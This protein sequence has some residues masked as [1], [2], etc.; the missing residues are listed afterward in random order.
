VH[1]SRL[2]SL[3]A[4]WCAAAL[5]L[6][7]PAGAQQRPD[8]A[9][10]AGAV[11]ADHPLA[12]AAGAEV[13]RRGGNAVDAAITMAAVLAV[14]RPHVSGL[15]GDAIML[16]RDAA[17]GRVH[18]LNGSGRA[19]DLAA[20]DVFAAHGLGSVPADGLLSV[21]VP[22]AVRLWADALRRFGTL[23]LDAALA[24]AI[25][26]AENG[27][28]VSAKL[29]AEL[30]RQRPKLE[31][32]SA[33]RA[34]FLRNGEPPLIGT[35]LRQADLAGS[36]RLIGQDGPDV[37]YVGEIARRIDAF[38]A[39][40]GGLL[41]IEDLA[42][43]STLWQEPIATSYAGYRVL[44]MPP[45]TQGIALLMQ[46]NMAGTLDLEG[47]G[48]NTTEY[49]HALVELRRLAFEDRDRH[50]A[51]PAFVDVPL[52]QLLSMDHARRRVA[53]LSGG[54][55]A[56]NGVRSSGNGGDTG[57]GDAAF[58]AVI[59]RDGNA[60]SLAQSLYHPFGSGRVVPGTGIVLHNRGA[61]F[62]LDTAHPNVI[63]PRKRPVHALSPALALR[64]DGS[65]FMAFGT[66]GSDAQ[67]PTLLQVFHNVVLF[68][69]TP[70]QAVE[71]P[72]F[73]PLENGLLLIDDALPGLAWQALAGLGYSV[74][75]PPAPAAAMGGA[76]LIIVLPSGVRMI[77]ADPRREA[78]G[79]AW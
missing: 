4:L 17:T 54:Q 31:A 30:L 9:G 57:D 66:A 10:V 74:R 29:A 43:H 1:R 50:I 77:G 3:S 28:P 5:L 15:G 44:G 2:R 70:Q 62:T 71:A 61:A 65:I 19:G 60:V 64:P 14:V 16:Y 51:D 42:A 7:A 40:D 26:Y 35:L 45:N 33:L 34:V 8:V 68:R 21:T 55:A 22:G 13:L 59:D 47:M 72:R 37:F 36:L 46:M 69:M 79:I 18:G 25:A 6:A 78:Y 73:R 39:G 20:P 52:E 12:A 11:V 76:Q 38:M 23:R 67:T 27:F 41:R 56:A 49:I 63:A 75:R 24:P 58:L 48:H 53:R 32:D